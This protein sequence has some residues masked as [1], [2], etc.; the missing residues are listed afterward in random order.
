VDQADRIE[1]LGGLAAVERVIDFLPKDGQRVVLSLPVTGAIDDF[2]ERHARRAATVPPRPAD[3]TLERTSVERGTLRFR[4]VTEPKE[5]GLLATVAELL[6]DD[7]RHVLVYCRT[8]DRAADVG[9]YLSLRGYLA[10]APGDTA[11]PVWLA[12]QELAARSA[13][14]GVEG[15]VVAS[16]DVPAD[17][18]SLDRR[19]GRQS[20]GLVLLVPRE[21]A[22]LR[23]VARRTG[24]ALH[25]WPPRR[26]RDDEAARFRD[27]LANA[28]QEEDVAPYLLLLEPLFE[29]FD[30]AEVA[31]A[32]VAL[33]RKKAPPPAPT[34]PSSATHGREAPPAWVKVFLTVGERDGLTAKDLV[35]AI[36]GEA[37][38]PGSKVGKIDIRESHTVVEVMEPVAAKV[39]SAL[40]GTT[41][42]GRSVR[43][44]FDRPKVRRGPE[45]ERR[46]GPPRGRPPRRG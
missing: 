43:A 35:G 28:V 17:P 46:G 20:G 41:I 42:R 33:L 27:Q 44:D 12:V 9:D 40:N 26:A 14:E 5:E 39:I 23:D 25:P 3:G 10:G 7:V 19:H 38:I 34:P 36:T 32:A 30:P 16:Y 37:D 11:V 1:R 21:L 6:A 31:A 2:V 18:D 8:E 4:I 45:G 29:R 24:Y 13:A 15:V 22:H